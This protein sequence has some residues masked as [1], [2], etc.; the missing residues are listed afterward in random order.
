MFF[1]YYTLSPQ[2]VSAPTGHPQVEQ[3][4]SR[5]SMVLSLLV[6][7]HKEEERRMNDITEALAE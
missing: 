1:I 7:K 5:L 2:H 4:I 3:N 6:H